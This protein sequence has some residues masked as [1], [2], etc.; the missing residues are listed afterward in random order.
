MIFKHKMHVTTKYTQQLMTIIFNQ[1]CKIFCFPSYFFWLISFFEEWWDTFCR[2]IRS[3][4]F[5]WIKSRGRYLCWVMCNIKDCRLLN[6]LRIYASTFFNIYLFTKIDTLTF[7]GR[8]WS[9]YQNFIVLFTHKLLPSL[10][11]M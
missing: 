2:K 5:T 11:M 1:F 9:N 4:A 3:S 8:T 6:V 10:W 7:P